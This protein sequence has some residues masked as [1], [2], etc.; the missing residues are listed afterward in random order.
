MKSIKFVVNHVEAER[1]MT[2][3]L[4]EKRGLK[5]DDCDTEFFASRILVNP[6]YDLS[7]ASTYSFSGICQRPR[8][9]D[10]IDWI[11]KNGK[12]QT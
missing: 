3:W 11:M 8:S 7:T 5:L 9:S 4:V 1:L 6:A 2:A 12:P 10:P